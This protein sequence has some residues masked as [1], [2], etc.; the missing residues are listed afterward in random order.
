MFISVMMKVSRYLCAVVVLI[1]ASLTPSGCSDVA[2]QALA[3]EESAAVDGVTVDRT[4]R[5]GDLKIDFASDL[6]ADRI[7]S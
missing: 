3:Y 2:E 7:G 5:D 6:D 1:V 4:E